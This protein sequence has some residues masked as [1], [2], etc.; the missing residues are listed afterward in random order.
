M[1]SACNIPAGRSSERGMKA[2]FP[3]PPVRFALVELSGPPLSVPQA[4]FE[5]DHCPAE[6]SGL[7]NDDVR[8]QSGRRLY[9]AG[10]TLFL[11]SFTRE[12][13]QA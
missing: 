1:L 13:T 2:A 5:S 6:A 10:L 7:A 11:S 3:A 8:E 9:A 4:R 12:R